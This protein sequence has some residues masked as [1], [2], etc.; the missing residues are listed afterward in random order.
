VTQTINTPTQLYVST[1][2][3]FIQF[4]YMDPLCDGNADG[5]VAQNEFDNLD[6]DDIDFGVDN[7]PFH[8]NPAQED[9]DG[10][11]LGDACD[12]CPFNA[13]NA[14]PTPQADSDGDGVGDACDFDDIDFDGVVNSVDNCP[15]VYNPFQTP[16]G[17]GSTR[18]AAC[19]QTT[20]RDGD[21]V[22]DRNDNCV[23]TYNPTQQ[24]RDGD[25]GGGGIA[26]GDAC[27]GDC[28]NARAAILATGSCNRSSHVVCTQ[29]SQCPSSGTCQETPTQVCTSSS[30]QCTCVNITQEVCVRIGTVNDGGCSLTNDDVDVDGVADFF[31]N[32]P[33]TYN[34]AIIPGTNK[35]AD[36]DN[37]GRGDVCDSPFMV[38]GDND[39]I[40]DDIV[41]FGV[42]VNCARVPLPSLVVEAA[43]VRDINGDM[44]PFCDTGETCEMTM[45]VANNSDIDLTNVTLHLATGDPDIECV[46]R[47]SV[48]IGDLPAGGRVDTASVGGERRPFEFTASQTVQTIVAADP[49][50]ADLVLSLTSR[51]AAGTRSKVAF[52]I[53]LDLDIPVGVEVTRVVGPDGIA[54]TADDGTIFEN[55]DID[56][57]AN[58]QFDLSDGRDGIP[59]DT[60]GFTVGTAQ[61]GLN[62]LA[63]IG[64]AGYNIPPA[65]PNCSIDADND[66]GWHIHCPPDTPLPCPPTQTVSG[67]RTY[68]VTPAD[69]EMAFSGNNSLHWGKH[70][71]TTRLGDTTSF[72]E[73]AAFTTLPINLT[74]LPIGGDLELSFFHIAVMMDNNEASLLGIPP[75]QSVDHGDVHIRVDLE[76]DPAVDAWG[77]WG[78]LAPFEN[79]Y[80]HVPYIW[81][82]WGTRITYCDLTP[83]DTGSAAPAPRGVHETMCM[84]LGV[85]SHCGNAYGTAHTFQCPGPGHPGTRTPPGGSL[86]VQSRFSLANFLGQRVQIRWIAQGWEFDPQGSS[87]DY[88]TYGRGWENNP[89]EDG[90]WV[91]D[92][93]IT[94]AI[95]AQVSPLADGKS[96]PPSTCPATSGDSCDQT[97]GD[98]GY[99][100]SVAILDTGNG[101]GIFER[102]EIIEFDASDTANPGGCANGV[103]L[104]R[105]LK[106]GAVA[107][108]YSANA[109][110]RDAPTSDATYQVLA[111]CSA[112]DACTTATGFTRAIQVYTGDGEDIRLSVSHDRGTGV[113][114][115]RWPARPQAPPMSGYDVFRGTVPPANLSSLTSIACDTGTG[116]PVGSDV[117]VTSSAAA[118]SAGTAHFYL[119]GHSNP[120]PGALTALGR[121]SNGSVRIA[122]ITCP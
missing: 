63:G 85:W 12:N 2:D 86:W 76:A 112:D 75:G 24:N 96:A 91:D 62:Q 14:P 31:D 72:R 5:V 30:P 69:G 107:Q 9:S 65:D 34:P 6:G 27:D 51:E 74:P 84:P 99:T 64:C 60:I 41:S 7:C 100:V 38:D 108:D 70:A 54:G 117:V 92:I 116:V 52:Q 49:A 104:F 25:I 67:N 114:T 109:F 68:Y 59:N 43:F 115:L 16:A 28:L 35:Q 36:S 8:Y 32:C 21:G 83:T 89:H 50:K 13:N 88:F 73:L 101:D 40:P 82:Y 23:R 93:K 57:S 120:T 3:T 121:H 19:G 17:G 26:I 56:R 78:K 118:P 55:F 42:Q 48:F 37:D 15:D 103:T 87:Q 90:W 105:F 113:T 80:D 110:Y 39:G 106:N 66:M 1:G 45:I 81:S 79:V 111:R 102:N 95:T 97:Q 98:G 71:S 20:D 94:G 33:V 29:D 22:N 11:G 44:D 61:G 119:V 4:Y 77:F 53:L 10:D 18:G 58:G 46:R 47:P 122:P